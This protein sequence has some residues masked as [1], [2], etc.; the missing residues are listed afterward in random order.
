MPATKLEAIL[1]PGHLDW[2]LGSTRQIEL[3]YS[4]RARGVELSPL[5]DI[6]R[7]LPSQSDWSYFQLADRGPAWH[8]VLESGTIAMRLRE[9]MIDN[10]SDLTGNQTLKVRVDGE[11]ISLQFAIFAFNDAVSK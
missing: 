4:K 9:E 1:S 11:V 3:L 5:Q 7:L 2:K 10:R 8:D 6:P